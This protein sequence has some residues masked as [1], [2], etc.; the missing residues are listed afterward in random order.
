MD[1]AKKVNTEK[2]SNNYGTNKKSLKT[3]LKHYSPQFNIVKRVSTLISQAVLSEIMNAV[4]TGT[5][6]PFSKVEPIT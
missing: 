4:I 1:S 5:H 2:R 6:F 3:H